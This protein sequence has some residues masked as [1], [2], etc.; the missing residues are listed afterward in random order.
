MPPMDPTWLV[1]LGLEPKL[2]Q[3]EIK[4]KNKNKRLKAA[5]DA[6]WVNDYEHKWHPRKD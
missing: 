6:T 1:E 2:S 4:A 3:K 5:G